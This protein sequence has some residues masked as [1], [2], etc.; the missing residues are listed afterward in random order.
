MDNRVF[1]GIMT[2]IFNSI[3]VPCFLQGKVGKGVLRI[4]LNFISFGLIG[5]INGIMGIILGIEILRM[6]DE[7][8]DDRKGSLLKGIPAGV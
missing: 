4:V 3:G 8:F 6:S 1:Y 7:E 2:L 5:L